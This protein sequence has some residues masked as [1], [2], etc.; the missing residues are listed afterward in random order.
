MEYVLLVNE[1]M[2]G[3]MHSQRAKLNEGYDSASCTSSRSPRSLFATFSHWPFLEARGR[4]GLVTAYYSDGE[5][6][7]G[8]SKSFITSTKTTLVSS[9]QAITAVDL[10]SA[11]KLPINTRVQKYRDSV[12]LQAYVVS[13]PNSWH[14]IL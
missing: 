11:A 7:F 13:T 8:E 9:Q 10:Q 2:P 14:G 6:D 5:H 3:H 1:T 4:L 12:L